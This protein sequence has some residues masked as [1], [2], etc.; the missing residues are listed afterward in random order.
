M[1]HHIYKLFIM[2]KIL[3]YNILM[4]VILTSCSA[5]KELISF[6]KCEF[7]MKSLVSIKVA[8]VDLDGKTSIDDFKLTDMAVLTQHAIRGTFPFDAV[9]QIEAKNPNQQS[10]A[11]NK[12]EWIAYIDDMEMMSGFVNDRVVIPANNG[13]GLIPLHIQ[14]DMKKVVESSTGKAIANLALNLMNIGERESRF[15]VRIK[16]TVLVGSIALDYPGYINITKE[17]TSGN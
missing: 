14:F 16:P 13:V 8:G 11:I 6:T 15:T 5:L 12:V 10:A 2:K 1:Y 7:R 9:L 3:I 4:I 17:F